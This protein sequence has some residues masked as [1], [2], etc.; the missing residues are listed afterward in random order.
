MSPATTHTPDVAN[1]FPRVSGDEPAAPVVYP[2]PEECFPRVSGDEPFLR[3]Q[4]RSVF[5][6][7]PA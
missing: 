6:F 5:R 7:S 1:R 2:W 4:S 3:I